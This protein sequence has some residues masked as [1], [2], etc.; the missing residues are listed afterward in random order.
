[1]VGDL[2]VGRRLVDN[3][4]VVLDAPK[5]CDAKK[6]TP[7]PAGHTLYAKVHDLIGKLSHGTGD[8]SQDT[9]ADRRMAPKK[10]AKCIRGHG[11]EKRFLDCLNVGNAWLAVDGRMLS[12]EFASRYITQRDLAS[13]PPLRRYTDQTCD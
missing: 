13:A 12:E 6:L 7:D 4:G 10:R 9:L 8:A 2:P 1:M 3:C 5:S 11:G